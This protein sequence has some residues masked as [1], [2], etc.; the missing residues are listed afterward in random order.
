MAFFS[1]VAVLILI[2]ILSFFMPVR[3]IVFIAITAILAGY[4]GYHLAFYYLD[5]N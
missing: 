2:V 4:G 1:S 3:D 5:R